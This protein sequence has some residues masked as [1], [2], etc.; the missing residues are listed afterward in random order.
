MESLFSNTQDGNRRGS[1]V[2]LAGISGGI[3]TLIRSTVRHTTKSPASIAEGAYRF[4][5]TSAESI[6]AM[7]TLRRSLEIKMSAIA[8]TQECYLRFRYF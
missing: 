4:M 8:D 2:V 1:A 3:V 6:V 5:V 7:S